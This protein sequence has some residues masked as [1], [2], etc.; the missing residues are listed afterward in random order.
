MEQLSIVDVEKEQIS[1]T[2]VQM[3]YHNAVNDYTVLELMSDADEQVT[4]VGIMPMVHEDDEVIL[5]GAWVRHPEHGRQFQV[6]AC[7]KRLP[8]DVN[9]ILRY[10]S[11]K[12]VKGVGP[13]TALK[14][15]NR[16]G[17]DSFDVIEH[18]PEWLTDIPGITAKKAAD[19]NRSF[20][21]EVG[22]RN[23][24]MLCHDYI[25]GGEVTRIYK[26]FGASAVNRIRENPY[27]LCRTVHGIGFE[28][29]D[30]MA[31]DMGF[32]LRSPLRI[33][34]GVAY[35][36]QYNAQTN[37]HS[38]M[39]LDKAVAASAALLE[40]SEEEVYCTVRSEEAESELTLYEATDGTPYL[41]SAYMA[42]L[43]DNIVKKLIDIDRQAPQYA[44]SDAELFAERIERE[45]GIT[46][47][48]LQRQA[49]YDSLRN[50]VTILTGGPGTGK[51]TVIRGL[52]RIFDS[53]GVKVALAAPTG[54][55][56]KRMSEATNE[57]AKTVHRMLEM[58]SGRE[59]ETTFH[60]NED[61]PISEK[62][63][64]V[65]EASMLDIPLTEALLR[66][67]PRKGR[68]IFIGDS[69]QLPSVGAGNVLCDMIASEIFCTVKLNEIFRQ[70][71]ESLI[72]TN[73]HL[74]NNGKMPELSVKDK[75][76]FFLERASDEDIASTVRGLVAERL[77]KAY[78]KDIL[79]KL[80]II[81]PSRRGGGGTENLNA[82]LQAT[83][84]PHTIKKKEIR[85]KDKVFREGDR[86]MQTRNNYDVSW[87]KNGIDG[88]GIYNGDIG[89]LHS[90]NGA[91]EK[92]VIE[93]ED[94]TA[95]Y[96]F[97]LLEELEH[98]YAITVHKSQ[99]SEYSVVIIPIYSCAPM[100]RTRNLLYTAVTRA[101]EMVILVGRRDILAGM[102]E[103]NRQV[104]R[105]TLLAEKLRKRSNIF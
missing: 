79:S 18:H 16:F 103:N 65:D 82:I 91:E 4:C 81:S 40:L 76:F 63:I 52:I 11:S 37:G 70:F 86:V 57:E 8:S 31:K 101:K 89:V 33:L 22:M 23:L 36:L 47:A 85:F 59:G 64:I 94:K 50:G 78:G 74:I 35:V 84:N 98:A 2:V 100:L 1:G 66:A 95:V 14:I 15:V 53:L 24:M 96:D 93:F 60:R 32:D 10:L 19:I 38:C 80:Q 68:V 26:Q 67:V 3:I 12:N 71:G 87:Q 51:T 25:T 29:S 48:N 73:A 39:P 104:F 43:E 17:I 46:F 21:E 54:R 55:A 61:N 42:H 20:C 69:D 41:Y 34:S 28:R 5:Y 27:C 56:A 9:A 105:Y 72:V 44:F 99:G 58:E 102:V 49:I 92:L 75:D 7:E 97:S 45:L 88:M 90:I 6:D 83:L 77:P 30:K 62:V 13:V